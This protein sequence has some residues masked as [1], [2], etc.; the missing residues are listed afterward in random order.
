MRLMDSGDR[1]S[2][3][4]IESMTRRKGKDQH[5]YSFHHTVGPIAEKQGL[6]GVSIPKYVI[7]LGG[8]S[9]CNSRENGKK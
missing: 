7:S 9:L 2:I 3:F 5:I 8:W 4:V 6:D 1:V